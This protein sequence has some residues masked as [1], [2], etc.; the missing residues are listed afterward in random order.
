MNFR[1]TIFLIF[2]L[3]ILVMIITVPNSED[4]N[5]WLTKEHNMKVLDKP[6]GIYEYKNEKIQDMV[7]IIKG[8]GVFMTL[9]KE[10]E[11]ENGKSFTIKGIGMFDNIY[12]TQE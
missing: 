8:Y 12:T 1:A 9:E 11:Y 2:L 7:T 5:E 3:I 6:Y 10:F 4:I